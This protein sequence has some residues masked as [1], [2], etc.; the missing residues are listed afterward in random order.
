MYETNKNHLE[1]SLIN[2]TARIKFQTVI[3][4]KFKYCYYIYNA[5]VHYHNEKEFLFLNV[6][7][8]FNSVK[9]DIF[10]YL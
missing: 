9:H 7:N 1:Q 8:A 5:I 6:S 3:I 10:Y 4:F 2:I